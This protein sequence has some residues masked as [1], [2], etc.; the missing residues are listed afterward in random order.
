MKNSGEESKDRNSSG[1]IHNIFKCNGDES[2]Q[3]LTEKH[4]VTLAEKKKEKKMIIRQ[5]REKIQEKDNEII[6]GGS[7]S[8]EKDGSR[9]SDL[10]HEATSPKNNM[11]IRDIISKMTPKILSKEEENARTSAETQMD[12]NS[13]SFNASR[14]KIITSKVKEGGNIFTKGRAALTPAKNK[15]KDKEKNQP[16]LF[17]H[18]SAKRNDKKD[19]DENIQKKSNFVFHL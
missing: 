16:S 8:D 15:D 12:E 4:K 11:N 2:Y 5:E 14:T 18:F 3:I 6:V 13:N 10:S 19:L 9:M 1:V 17:M 7:G